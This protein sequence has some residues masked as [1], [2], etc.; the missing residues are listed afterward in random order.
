[1]TA[2]EVTQTDGNE[3][4]TSGSIDTG[5]TQRCSRPV[6]NIDR[7]S[8]ERLR[9]LLSY[10]PETG[11]FMWRK[12]TSPMCKLDRPAGMIKLCGYR[13]IVIDGVSYLASHLAW[14]H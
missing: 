10:D 3:S 11:V 7:L 8:V 13:R 4:L 9:E 6:R 2:R 5:L 1:M 14:L 12:R